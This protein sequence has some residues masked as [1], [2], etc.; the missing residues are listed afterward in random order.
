ME[1]TTKRVRFTDNIVKNKHNDS[2]ADGPNANVMFKLSNDCGHKRGHIPEVVNPSNDLKTKEDH[3]IIKSSG[4][5]KT[6]KDHIPEVINSSN[7]FEVKRDHIPKVINLSNDC[8]SKADL[9]IR[10]NISVE[11][12][13]MYDEEFHRV[14]YCEPITD[15]NSS[16]EESCVTNDDSF[17]FDE[18]YDRVNPYNELIDDSLSGDSHYSEIYNSALSLQDISDGSELYCTAT[19]GENTTDLTP[20]TPLS[21]VDH[22]S[23]FN[24]HM[25]NSSEEHTYSQ[26]SDVLSISHI[27]ADH[28]F[29]VSSDGDNYDEEV[30]SLISTD[31]CKPSETDDSGYHNVPEPGEECIS[32]LN[33]DHISKVR[34]NLEPSEGLMLD[35]SGYHNISEPTRVPSYEPKETHIFNPSSQ[36]HVFYPGEYLIPAFSG[37]HI[38]NPH[39]DHMPDDRAD[40]SSDRINYSMGC[41][42]RGD[43][44]VKNI[45]DVC[46]EHISDEMVEVVNLLADECSIPYEK[47]DQIKLSTISQ[48]SKDQ[49]VDEH[50][51]DVSENPFSDEDIDLI[52]FDNKCHNSG[53]EEDDVTKPSDV[54]NF[55][56]DQCVDECIPDSVFN[57]VKGSHISDENLDFVKLDNECDSNGGPIFQNIDEI[58]PSKDSDLYSEDKIA[59][60]QIPKKN[61]DVS[62][63]HV[64]GEMVN[65]S[66]D[67]ASCENQILNEN[68][69]N[70]TEYD[71][72]FVKKQVMKVLGS[73]EV[74]T[75]MS[76][77]AWYKLFTWQFPYYRNF[78]K[79]SRGENYLN[80][81]KITNLKKGR[82]QVISGSQIL[83]PDF[84]QMGSYYKSG[85][86]GLSSVESFFSVKTYFEYCSKEQ[87]L[88]LNKMNLIPSMLMDKYQPKIVYQDGYHRGNLVNSYKLTVSLLDENEQELCSRIH[89]RE[90][91]TKPGPVDWKKVINVF[92]KYPPGVR[93]IRFRH[94]GFVKAG[95]P[96]KVAHSCV[97]LIPSSHNIAEITSDEF[98]S[99]SLKLSSTLKRSS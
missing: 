42:L 27:S 29:S 30:D 53:E 62:A 19:N 50:T 83:P 98:E 63:D 38:S 37:N 84:I 24:D 40:Q 32:E 72:A 45:P 39:E 87:L 20:T 4:N 34:E 82:W 59:Y 26:T 36:D 71:E 58:T 88:N 52:S 97:Y 55:I 76:L 61:S 57:D 12:G 69:S 74:E 49:F 2:D 11:D 51:S 44:F 94:G 67:C 43:R 96:L 28:T 14:G 15:N 16:D 85:N 31:R 1:E 47:V 79:N 78:L 73:F 17:S 68:L 3:E 41:G 64:L 60:I 99:S 86:D 23:D 8:K 48:I 35:D 9:T 66:N 54:S 56:E 89:F 13:Y 80:D 92:D 22:M 7:E 65:P 77:S 90:A 70:V 95:H 18:E 25:S 46:G 10:R 91:E 21:E 5:I 75:K 6:E 33:E 93:F 81:W